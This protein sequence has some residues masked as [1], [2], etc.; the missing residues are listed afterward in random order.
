MNT[1]DELKQEFANSG[2]KALLSIYESS[3]L[4]YQS[5]DARG[6]FLDVNQA[7]LQAFGYHRGEVIGAPF[8]AFMSD[9]SAALVA[10][11]FPRLKQE[12]EVRDAEFSHRAL[13]FC[14][15][16][17]FYVADVGQLARL[18]VKIAVGQ[19]GSGFH[20]RKRN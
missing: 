10:Q 20:G 8:V 11:D 5:L 4:P 2:E 1:S 12:G 18:H 9:D 16:V 6:C 15:F 17:D 7:W 3:P 13:S 14:G 19:A